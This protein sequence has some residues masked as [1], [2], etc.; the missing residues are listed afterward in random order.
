MS[1]I[2]GHSPIGI[3]TA[4]HEARAWLVQH[5]APIVCTEPFS[6]CLDCEAHNRCARYSRHRAEVTPN[7]AVS[8]GGGGA[9]VH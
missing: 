2:T 5:S 7:I 8:G 1:P 6:R 9:D 3:G 4:L